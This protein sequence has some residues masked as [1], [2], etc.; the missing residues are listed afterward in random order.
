[1]GKNHRKHKTAKRYESTTAHKRLAQINCE[2]RKQVKEMR[3]SIPI[4]YAKLAKALGMEV[5]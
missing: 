5:F 1:M 3:E 2:L 4:L